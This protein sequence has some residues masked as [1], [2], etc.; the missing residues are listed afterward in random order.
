MSIYVPGLQ[1]EHGIIRFFRYHRG[2][3]LPSA[4]LMSPMTRNFVAGLEAF[5]ARYRI[6]L[7]QFEKRQRKDTVTVGRA[8]EL[9]TGET[10]QC[11]LIGH[12]A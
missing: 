9:E 12:R 10:R 8:G 5:A 7:A 6:P 4:A 1:Y 3:P 11:L 2:Q